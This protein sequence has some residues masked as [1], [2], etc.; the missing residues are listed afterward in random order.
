MSIK[1]L[2]GRYGRLTIQKFVRV[3][4][5]VAWWA[6]ECDCGT[7]LEVRGASLT[8]TYRPTRSCGCL[9]KDAAT[10]TG[11]ANRVHGHTVGGRRSR[12]FT[13]W[14]AMLKRC[15]Q[16]KSHDF[17][18]YGGRGVGVC[19]RWHDFTAFLADMGER[20]AGMTLDRIDPYG[21]YG[22]D[23]CRW[24]TPAEQARNRRKR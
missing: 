20:P 10:E 23:N 11:L 1:V 8:R 17:K 18:Y 12:T 5:R 22:K 4:D 21:N 3:R 6:C 7:S 19:Q 9:Q 14:D 15:E 13:T 16:P 24:S 2:S